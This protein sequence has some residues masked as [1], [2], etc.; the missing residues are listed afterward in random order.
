MPSEPFPETI[1]ETVLAIRRHQAA[2]QQVQVQVIQG[3]LPMPEYNRVYKEHLDA[4]H[5]L[6]AHMAGLQGG[7]HHADDPRGK[8]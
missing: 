3:K 4:I 8:Y 2:L 1:E 5:A 6:E 7:H